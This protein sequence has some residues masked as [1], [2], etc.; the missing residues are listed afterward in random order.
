M[1]A[2]DPFASGSPVQ[3]DQG[4]RQADRVVAVLG[5]IVLLLLGFAAGIVC[6]VA[7]GWL[8]WLWAGGALGQ[9]VSGLLLVLYLGVLFAGCRVAGWSMGSRLGAGLPAAGWI[10]GAFALAEVSSAGDIVM[11]S[12]TITYAYLFG[13]MV[14]VV[15]ATVLTRP[16]D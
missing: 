16:G 14:T 11:T 5:H 4:R 6:G 15:L 10:A 8:S 7:A 2:P 1:A 12:S 9:A 13:G 3:G